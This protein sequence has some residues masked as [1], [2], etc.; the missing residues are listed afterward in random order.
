MVIAVN[1]LP[2]MRILILG[3]GAFVG[4]AIT[5]AATSRGHE[6]TT[7]TRST[8][9][10]GAESGRVEAMFGDRTEP[11]AFD[12]AIDRQ[13]DAVFDTWSGAPRIVQQ[14]V[15][16]LRPHASYY[17]YVSS[18]SVY[19]E[20]PAVS[21]LNEDAQTAEADPSA[22]ATNYS[23][24]KRGA[25]LAVLEGFGPEASLLARPGLILG[26]HELPGRLLWWL[27]RIEQGGEVLAPGPRDLALQ[28]IDA[29]DLAAW[30]VACAE[31]GTVGA[32]N[33]ISASGHTNMEE[34]LEACRFITN[35]DAEFTWVTPEFVIEQGI[36]PWSEMPIWVDPAS[37]GIH[38]FDTS[39]AAS[40]G[41]TCRPMIETVADTW[42]WMHSGDHVQ[43]PARLSSPGL[44][45]EKERAALAAWASQ[46]R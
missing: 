4:R 23:A 3:G 11:G 34:V 10:P 24:D 19:K 16:V 40:A 17:G 30:M 12:F 41:L 43:M 2:N 13:W 15:K 39:R 33:A 8:L 32:F 37:H 18:C 44:S 28:Y 25:E 45:I 29:R 42:A 38:S 26:P 35:S 46:D 27:R 21:G 20:A 6:V 7:F 5:E 1:R 31:K 14:S 36:Q 22:D 9:P